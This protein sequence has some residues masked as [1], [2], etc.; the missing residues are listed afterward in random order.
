MASTPGNGS[1]LKVTISATPTK[2]GQQFKF[3]GIKQTRPKIDF[4]PIDAAVRTSIPGMKDSDAIPF[5][6]F[7][8]AGDA[9]QAYLQT[10]IASGLTEAWTVSYADA[11][12]CNITFSGYLTELEYG[13]ATLDNLVPISG[14]IQA[15]TA[16]TVTP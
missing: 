8:D 11:G 1:I 7:M 5:S 14:V 15:T 16:I 3:G 4:T 10:S 9:S 12:T 2:I 13:E 6:A